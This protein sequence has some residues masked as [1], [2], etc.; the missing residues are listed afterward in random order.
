ML[1]GLEKQPLTWGGGTKNVDKKWNVG[2]EYL[3]SCE[4][5]LHY[6]INNVNSKYWFNQ[7]PVFSHDYIWKS[8]CVVRELQE[9]SS[10]KSVDIYEVE[11]VKSIDSN[12]L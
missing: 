5:Y 8:L 1:Y 11:T 10:C 3:F 7:K 2:L 9:T 12:Y 4:Q 6:H